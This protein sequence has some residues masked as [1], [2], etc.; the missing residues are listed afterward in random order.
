MA[1]KCLRRHFCAEMYYSG[2]LFCLYPIGSKIKKNLLLNIFTAV[3]ITVHSIVWYKFLCLK[4]L[5]RMDTFEFSGITVMIA[6]AFLLST[7]SAWKSQFDIKH[8]NVLILNLPNNPGN[9]PGRLIWYIVI[10]IFDIAAD[11][12]IHYGMT[13]SPSM[14]IYEELMSL[15]YIGVTINSLF[16]NRLLKSIELKVAEIKFQLQAVIVTHNTIALKLRSNDNFPIY[17]SVSKMDKIVTSFLG[18]LRGIQSFNR[19]FGLTIIGL[20]ILAT[21]SIADAMYI[22]FISHVQMQTFFMHCLLTKKVIINIGYLVYCFL[23]IQPCVKT[24]SHLEEAVKITCR[25]STKLPHNAANPSYILFQRKL[26]LLNKQLTMYKPYFS[27]AGVFD[28]DY[29]IFLYIF[30]GISSVVVVYVQLR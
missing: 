30:A 6:T 9:N 13:I 21:I 29:S 22:A 23:Y 4:K 11:I 18:I 16:A 5:H 14:F 15:L 8:W 19:I 12:Y 17:M 1:K 20:A 25:L 7:I 24:T 28:V 2:L 27:A 3:M 26:D 10:V